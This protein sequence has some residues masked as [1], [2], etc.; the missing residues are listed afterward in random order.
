MAQQLE[1]EAAI[2]LAGGALSVGYRVRNVSA[3]P[4]LLFNVLWDVPESAYVKAPFPAYVCVRGG[5]ELH[6]AQQILP[7][8]K[9]MKLEV[10][11]VPFVTR[12]APGASTA[13]Q[14]TFPVPVEEYSVYYPQDPKA[15]KQLITVNRVVFTLQYMAETG[16]V[17]TMPAPLEGALR[18][19]HPDLFSQVRTID[20]Q[21]MSSPDIHVAKAPQPFEEF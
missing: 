3:A 14:L 7:H 11:N 15:E 19:E 4:L 2:R 18:V 1:M 6:V 12:L 16:N 5:Q 9:L 17:K 20:S 8:P 10:R 21:P 13:A